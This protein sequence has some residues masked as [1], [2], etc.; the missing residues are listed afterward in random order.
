MIEEL[1][2]RI[3]T[4]GS[5]RDLCEYRDITLPTTPKALGEGTSRYGGIDRS[6]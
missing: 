4:E 2:H 5:I 1:S 6:N 3:V